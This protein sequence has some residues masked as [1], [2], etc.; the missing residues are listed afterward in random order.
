MS[1]ETR[2]TQVT[3]RAFLRV[4][5]L[6]GGTALLAACQQAPAPAAKPA[7]STPAET[8]PAAPAAAP[9]NRNG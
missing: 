6:F 1:A 5:T 7:E 2:T 8:K 3:R 4:A 9:W